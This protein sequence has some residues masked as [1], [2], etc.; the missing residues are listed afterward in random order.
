MTAFTDMLNGIFGDEAPLIDATCDLLIALR[1]SLTDV[2]PMDF[3]AGR[4]GRA[5]KAAAAGSEDAGQAVTTACRKL[6]IETIA[7]R[8]VPAATRVMETIGADYQAWAWLIDRE[9]VS[10]VALAKVKSDAQKADRKA[11]K[12]ATT[13]T[14]DTIAEDLR[15]TADDQPIF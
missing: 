14:A 6:Q 11:R 15:T 9:S 12:D 2:S 10:I 13:I 5:L 4:A 1:D 8:A 7:P 3:W